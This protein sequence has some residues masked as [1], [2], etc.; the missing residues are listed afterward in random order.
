[1]LA[2]LNNV[3]ECGAID[4]VGAV[5]DFATKLVIGQ[6]TKLYGLSSNVAETALGEVVGRGLK[7]ADPNSRDI[8]GPYADA[9][10][11]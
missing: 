6:Y 7:I 11:P 8:L 9:R 4:G 2:V 1:M 10:M 3:E 5:T